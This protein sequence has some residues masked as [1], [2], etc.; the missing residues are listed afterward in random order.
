[1]NFLG[2]KGV[3]L[4][5]A[6]TL[7]TVGAVWIAVDRYPTFTMTVLGLYTAFVGAHA[8]QIVMTTKRAAPVEPEPPVEEEPPV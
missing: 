3:L 5:V 7:V 2:R 6:M 4:L 8:G 1:M